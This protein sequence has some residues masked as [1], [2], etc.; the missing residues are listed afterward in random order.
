MNRVLKLSGLAVM[1]SLAACQSTRPVRE[2]KVVERPVPVA[3]KP[4]SAADIPGVPAPLPP[5]PSDLSQA[6]DLLLAKVC[7]LVGYV[8]RADPLLRLSAGIDA[9]AP[10]AFPECE[11]KD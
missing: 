3:E 11:P 2:V 8:R 7:E 10:P 6:A 1:I 9:G 4:I 5:R